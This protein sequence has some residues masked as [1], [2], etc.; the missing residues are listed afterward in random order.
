MIDS[1]IELTSERDSMNADFESLNENRHKMG[2]KMLVIEDQMVV[3]KS[4]KLELKNQLDLM[5]EKS[6]KR[7][8]ESTSLQIE[9]EENLKTIETK[10]ALALE[11][12]SNLE[13]DL[14]QSKEE[15]TI[16]LKWTKSSK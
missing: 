8:G 2:E 9:V 7:K 6:G 10:I 16:F 11:R 12:N 14:V 3:L 5:I 1:V 13:R 15:L 4:K